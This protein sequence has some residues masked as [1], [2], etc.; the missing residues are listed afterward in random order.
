MGKFSTP[1]L[2]NMLLFLR[3]FTA[4]G[5]N[6][7]WTLH[8]AAY[9]YLIKFLIL[10]FINQPRIFSFLVKNRARHL[11]ICDPRKNPRYLWSIFHNKD[12]A[13]IEPKNMEKSNSVLGAGLTGLNSRKTYPHLN[14]VASESK[15]STY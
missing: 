8:L 1:L 12:K 7:L 11:N 15:I 6:Y 3:S 2:S 14:H 13:K 9:I 4:C 5:R 10:C